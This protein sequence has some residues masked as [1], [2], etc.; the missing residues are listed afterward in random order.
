MIF[1][2]NASWPPVLTVS[3]L[4][5][6]SHV[7]VES[8]DLCIMSPANAQQ[9]LLCCNQ[10]R[11]MKHLWSK[12]LLARWNF[13]C[14]NKQRLRAVICDTEITY[15]W[16]L[17]LWNKMQTGRGKHLITRQGRC[18]SSVCWSYI[19]H[20]LVVQPLADIASW[21]S[22]A[23]VIVVHELLCQ[24]SLYLYQSVSLEGLP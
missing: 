4:G 10:Q 7:S 20:V 2:L 12:M 1:E 6:S 15:L 22:P 13:W 14:N 9:K 24:C 17:V 21:P 11:N 19:Y 16:Q 5:T 8:E 23:V 18:L 3:T